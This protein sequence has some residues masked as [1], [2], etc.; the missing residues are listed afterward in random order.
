MHRVH[1]SGG[2]AIL[3][4]CMA[5]AAGCGGEP[6]EEQ[7][8]RSAAKMDAVAAVAVNLQQALLVKDES[9]ADLL[10]ELDRLLLDHLRMKRRQ[11]VTELGSV[12]WRNLRVRDDI[13]EVLLRLGEEDSETA[14]AGFAKVVAG[15][16]SCHSAYSKSFARREGVE[17][18]R[19]A[20]MESSLA[21]IEGV[22]EAWAARRP[23][24]APNR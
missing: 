6:L 10:R 16:E 2:T 19:A 12:H 20:A 15:C 3:L 17:N 24:G 5:L 1:G 4:A 8:I 21:E 13:E 23:V 18:P 11:G 7:R 22:R 9:A 14:L